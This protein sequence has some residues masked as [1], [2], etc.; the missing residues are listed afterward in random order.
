MQGNSIDGDTD[1]VGRTFEGIDGSG[2][3][4]GGSTFVDCTFRNCR[5]D[6]AIF[7]R[8]FDAAARAIDGTKAP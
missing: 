5:F 1:H 4:L 8:C 3:T 7:D 6:E 2:E